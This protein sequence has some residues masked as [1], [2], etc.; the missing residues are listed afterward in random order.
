MYPQPIQELIDTLTHLPGI[1]P[2]QATR[3][4]FFLLKD[5]QGVADAIAE[6]LRTMR[7]RVGECAQCWRSLEMGKKETKQ[8]C[9]ICKDER[10]DARQIAVVEKEA[11]LHNIE[12]LATY[13]GAYHILGGVISPLDTDSPKRLHLRAL[14]NRVEELAK[15]NDKP[16][17]IILA[18]GSTTE[19]DTTA[20]YIERILSPLKEKHPHLTISRLGRGLSLGAELEYADEVTLTNALTNR[21]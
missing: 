17:E 3:F 19:G 15:K 21:R 7:E 9:A 12:K 13:R 4:A 1:G 20:I 2:R 10:R 14:Y 8:L 5:R 16:A 6:S 18:T 11:D